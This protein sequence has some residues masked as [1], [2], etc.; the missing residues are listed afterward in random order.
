M[1]GDGTMVAA[2]GTKFEQNK[3]DPE[4]YIWVVR[5]TDGHYMW[6]IHEIIHGEN[7]KGNLY[8]PAG[9]MHFDSYGTVYMA[10]GSEKTDKGFTNVDVDSKINDH[11]PKFAIAGFTGSTGAKVFYHHLGIYFGEAY[12]VTYKDYGSGGS[13]LFVGGMVDTCYY[14]DGGPNSCFSL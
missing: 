4:G 9:A 10:F 6:G 14:A 3:L 2:Y 5:A 1:S 13:N 11:I 8:V 7:D 12:A